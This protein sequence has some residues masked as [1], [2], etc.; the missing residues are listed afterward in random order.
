MLAIMRKVLPERKFIDDMP[1][2]SKLS[3][4][5]D[6]TQVID[7]MKKWGGEEH[8]DGFVSLEQTVEENLLP[9]VAWGY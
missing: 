4:S 5:T 3:I 2:L 1:N 8:R 7:L 9:V 6:L